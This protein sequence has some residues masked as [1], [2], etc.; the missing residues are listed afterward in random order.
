ME[1]LI[2]VCRCTSKFSL[3][4][5][6]IVCFCVCVCVCVCVFVCV[7]F[8]CCCCCLFVFLFIFFVCG[9]AKMI[10]LYINFSRNNTV[11]SGG[12][13]GKTAAFT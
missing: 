9:A 6:D 11:D 13:P 10:M 12:L 8:F 4:A 2:R 3:E 7:F 1:A 5:Y